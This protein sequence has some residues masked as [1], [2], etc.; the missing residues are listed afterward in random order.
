MLEVKILQTIRPICVTYGIEAW[1]LTIG[2]IHKFKV[3]HVDAMDEV[4]FGMCLKDGTKVT[5]ITWLNW[6]LEQMCS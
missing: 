5:D 4:K 3:K 2:V 1:T 6:P